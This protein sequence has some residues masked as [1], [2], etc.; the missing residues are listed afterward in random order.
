MHRRSNIEHIG[1]SLTLL[2][3]L[4]VYTAIPL[5]HAQ[6]GTNSTAFTLDSQPY[7]S[8][9]AEWT[10]SFWKW[11]LEQPSNTNPVNDQTGKNCAN[12]QSDPDVWFVAGTGGGSAERTCTIPSGKAILVPIINVVCSYATDPELKTESELRSCAKQDQDNVRSVE[13]I[14]DGTKLEDLKDYRVQSPLFDVTLPDNNIFQ[15]KPGPTKAV[16]DGYWVLLQ[17]LSPGKHELKYSGVL[18][19]F[20]TTSTTN[21]ATEVEYHLDVK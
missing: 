8:S 16:S 15:G 5:A 6:T 21:F 20:T 3:T 11:L 19:D 4:V 14:L 9:Y 13:L 12:N 1:L 7:G 2:L 17:P 18:V 10:A